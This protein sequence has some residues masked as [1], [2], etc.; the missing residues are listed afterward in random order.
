MMYFILTKEK[1]YLFYD[2]KK[3][4]QYNLIT[5]LVLLTQNEM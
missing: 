2:Y 4:I 3:K 1:L 5:V